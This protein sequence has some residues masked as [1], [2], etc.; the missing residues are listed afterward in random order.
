MAP[1]VIQSLKPGKFHG[2]EEGLKRGCI[3]AG[4]V[5]RNCSLVAD[6]VSGS[7]P[8]GSHSEE[9]QADHR[10]PE[11]TFIQRGNEKAL[12]PFLKLKTC[13]RES[14]VTAVSS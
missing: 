1:R 13:W 8:V 6:V 7:H 2:V 14:R 9:R 10:A 5:S 12:R 4:V 11:S 3:R